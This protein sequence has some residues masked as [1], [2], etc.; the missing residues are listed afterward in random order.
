MLPATAGFYT[1]AG[2]PNSGPH[3]YTAS[4]L[5]SKSSTRPWELILKYKD[6]G[7]EMDL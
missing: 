2:D 4:P 6:F 1:G 7:K 5:S 3:G